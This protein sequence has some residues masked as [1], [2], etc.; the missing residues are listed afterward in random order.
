MIKQARQL[1][2]EGQL[3]KVRKV[4][5]EYKGGRH[6]IEDQDKNSVLVALT[7]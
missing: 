7:Q 4:I 2:S 6:K 3:G 1:I 5:V